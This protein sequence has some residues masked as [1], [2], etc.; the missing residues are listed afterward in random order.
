MF[1]TV[2]KVFIHPLPA[3]IQR[4]QH[5]QDIDE[6]KNDNDNEG[7]MRALDILKQTFHGYEHEYALSVEGQVNRLIAP[8]TDEN[9]LAKMFRGLAF[10]M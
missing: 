5:N 4:L 10:W 9:N 2:L 6:N 1:Y 3:K 8:A 7:A